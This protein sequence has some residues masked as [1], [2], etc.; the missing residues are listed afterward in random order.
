VLHDAIRQG[1]SF[2]GRERHCSFLNLRD[3]TFADISPVSGLDFPDDGRGVARVDWDHD[4]D[5]DFWMV[6][7]SGPQVRF[8]RNDVP[9]ENNFLVVHLRGR[10]CNRDAIGSRVELHVKGEAAPLIRTLSAGDGFLAQSSKALHFGLGEAS[11]IIRLVVRWPGGEAEEFSGLEI[12]GHYDVEQQSGRAT[13]RPPR[14]SLAWTPSLLTEPRSSDRAQ[15]LS[16]SKLPLPKLGYTTFDGQR[17][18][19][20]PSSDDG[21]PEGIL[22]NLWA[23]WC[24]PCLA[25]LKEWTQ[26]ADELRAAGIRVVAL[27]VDGLEG[28]DQAEAVAASKKIM[29]RIGVSF[30]SGMATARTVEIL[31]MVHDHLFDVHRP[32]PVPTSFLIDPRGN[33]AA[34]YKG[35]IEVDQLL[36]DVRRLK[37]DKPAASSVFPGRWLKP[38][39]ARNPFQLVWSM[40]EQ[41]FLDESLAYIERNEALLARHV[42][43][44]QLLVLAGNG[45]LGRGQALQ[46]AGLFRKALKIAPEHAEAQNNLAWLLATQPS[47]QIRNGAEA[48]RLAESAVQKVGEVPSYLGTLA[49][50]YAEAGRFPEAIVTAKK[51]VRIATLQGDSQLAKRME[52]RLKY[53]EAGKPWHSE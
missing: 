11:E 23:S 2:S 3:G 6:N 48:V 10:S 1:S 12:N 39:T 33:L 31:Q 37:S 49:V 46:A 36:S 44:H 53:F 30:E 45:E 15:I 43:Y 18:A 40:I 20:S 29:E 28:G 51:A 35:R 41:G 50:A 4:G 38:R 42:E 17:R 7:R 25:E 22:L 5:L 19:V 52:S 13:R 14:A 26:R 16:M 32:L 47:D 34:I 21:A 8:L 27:S 9:H 24:P